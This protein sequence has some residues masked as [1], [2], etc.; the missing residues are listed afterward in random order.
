MVRK[1]YHRLNID[2]RSLKTVEDSEMVFVPM[3]LR[4]LNSEMPCSVCNDIIDV[5]NWK[6]K[7]HEEGAVLFYYLLSNDDDGLCGI[8]MCSHC[9]GTWEKQVLVMVPRMSALIIQ[10][11]WRSWIT[12]R[13]TE[14]MNVLLAT[15][16]IQRIVRAFLRRGYMNCKLTCKRFF[17]NPPADEDMLQAFYTL[18]EGFS[19]ST[20]RDIEISIPVVRITYTN[21]KQLFRKH[22]ELLRAFFTTGKLGRTL[23]LGGCLEVTLVMRIGD[24]DRPQRYSVLRTSVARWRVSDWTTIK[25]CANCYQYKGVELE[26]SPLRKCCINARYCSTICQYIHWKQHKEECM[27]DSSSNIAHS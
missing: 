18:E 4:L 20:L 23:N 6:S 11:A 10:A 12:R 25:H 14:R 26:Q 21:N 27:C 5:A 9:C 15:A 24:N 8:R 1:L 13:L 7:G 16:R 3:L 2:A 22:P 19:V 17:P